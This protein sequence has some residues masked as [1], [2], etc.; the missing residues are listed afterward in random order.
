MADRDLQMSGGD[1]AA[2]SPGIS[3]TELIASESRPAQA[4][5]TEEQFEY[6][7][8]EPLAAQR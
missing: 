3:W 7:G 4:C 1:G 2:R 5:H 8:S 6:I